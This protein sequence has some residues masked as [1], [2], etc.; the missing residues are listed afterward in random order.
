MSDVMGALK[1]AGFAKAIALTAGDTV[2]VKPRAG[3]TSTPGAPT[4]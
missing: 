2:E 4:S 1:R 3:G